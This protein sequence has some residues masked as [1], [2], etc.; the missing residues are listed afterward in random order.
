MRIQAV[1]VVFLV[2]NDKNSQD[3]VRKNCESIVS[4]AS[5]SLCWV[6]FLRTSDFCANQ[7]ADGRI[8]EEL[9]GA[10]PFQVWVQGAQEGK[11]APGCTGGF[12][13][14]CIIYIYGILGCPDFQIEFF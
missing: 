7:Y 6:R 3:T 8:A 9:P 13:L 4:I 5:C 10:H 2:N 14:G 12:V 11:N 1:E